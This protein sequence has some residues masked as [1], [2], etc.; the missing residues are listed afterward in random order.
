MKKIGICLLA[1]GEEHINEALFLIKNLMYYKSQIDFYVGTNCVEKFNNLPYVK[2]FEITEDFNYNLKRV[3]VK[4]AFKDCDIVIMMDSD[5]M[6]HVLYKGDI[7][8]EKINFNKLYSLDD[9]MYCDII[10]G[11]N[12][13]LYH[14]YQKKIYELSG[15][16]EGLLHLYEH[17]IFLKITDDK[18]KDNFIKNWEFFYNESID[19]QPLSLDSNQRGAMEGLLIYGCIHKSGL[20]FTRVFNNPITDYIFNRFYHYNADKKKQEIVKLKGRSI[21]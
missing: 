3:A 21:I 4:E 19:E 9:G 20:K 18:T 12:L 17:I 14:R 1:Y 10:E 11:F 7:T 2:V 15:N 13:N 6:E 5:V 16:F 8:T